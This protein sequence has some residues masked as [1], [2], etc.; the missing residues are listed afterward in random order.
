MTERH[1]PAGSENV[2]LEVIK[3]F[4]LHDDT[5]ELHSNG[6][7]ESERVYRVEAKHRPG[8]VLRFGDRGR[9]LVWSL[10]SEGREQDCIGNIKGLPGVSYVRRGSEEIIWVHE[11]LVTNSTV[12]VRSAA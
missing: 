9:C 11:K 2:E 3:F 12:S 10:G 1:R 5:A 7:K 4:K 6:R 8:I